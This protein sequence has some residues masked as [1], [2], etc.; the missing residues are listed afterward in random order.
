[1][2]EFNE[3]LKQFV[4][5][6]CANEDNKRRVEENIK[7][8]NYEIAWLKN[9]IGKLSLNLSKKPSTIRQIMQYQ[10][11]ILEL[12]VKLAFD[13]SYGAKMENEND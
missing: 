2:D 1:M 6:W 11:Q 3:S 8:A 5:S 4:H 9:E 13:P 12:R 7:R 10:H